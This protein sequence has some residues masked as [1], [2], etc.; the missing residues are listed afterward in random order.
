MRE[1]L[2]PSRPPKL[3]RWIG[4]HVPTVCGNPYGAPAIVGEIE[5]NTPFVFGEANRDG[6]L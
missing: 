4:N 1:R 6:V 2:H 3:H 5:I